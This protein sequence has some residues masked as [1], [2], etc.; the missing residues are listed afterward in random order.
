MVSITPMAPPVIAMVTNK[1]AIWWQK[2]MAA[3]SSEIMRVQKKRAK[4]EARRLR[5]N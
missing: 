5:M 2:G 3:N 1:G 4:R